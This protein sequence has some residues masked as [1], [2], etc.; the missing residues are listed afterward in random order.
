MLR[1]MFTVKFAY[2]RSVSGSG[3]TLFD[4]AIWGRY[5]VVKVTVWTTQWRRTRIIVF[6]G[7]HVC[8]AVHLLRNSIHQ[9]PTAGRIANI[10]QLTLRVRRRKVAFLIHQTLV[11][12]RQRGRAMWQRGL[13]DQCERAIPQRFAGNYSIWQ[14]CCGI[15]QAY[16]KSGIGSTSALL[17]IGGALKAQQN[18]WHLLQEE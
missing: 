1:R 6:D 8:L 17:K 10:Y 15:C 11:L 7:Y 5:P 4:A 16:Q 14:N 18:G 2:A 13:D 9:M 3:D 12:T